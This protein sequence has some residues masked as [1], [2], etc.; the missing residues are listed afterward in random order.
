M[1]KIKDKR[2]KKSAQDVVFDQ[3][4]VLQQQGVEMLIALNMTDKT[5]VTGPDFGI[6]AKI[7]ITKEKPHFFFNPEVMA[8]EDLNSVTDD[9]TLN[10]RYKN[11]LGNEKTVSINDSSGAIQ[12]AVNY[13]HN[14]EPR[15]KRTSRK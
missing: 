3:P 13:L 4:T 12:K 8:S 9:S 15:K 11:Y 7:L 1:L 14:G 10:M 6:D 2:P 5:V